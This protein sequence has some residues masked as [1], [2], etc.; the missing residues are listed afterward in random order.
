LGSRSRGYHHVAPTP[1]RYGPSVHRLWFRPSSPEALHVKRYDIP[2]LVKGGIGRDVTGQFSLRFR[3][4][5]KSQGS[6]TCRKS[7]TWDRRTDGQ[8]D[9]RLYILFEGRNAVNF[10]DRKIRRLRP[11]YYNVTV[12]NNVQLYPADGSG[13]L[14]R[15]PFILLQVC[16]RVHPNYS[17]PV[18]PFIQ[19]LW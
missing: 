2:L 18:L 7:A 15:N 19:Q 6:F 4:P 12:C 9:R 11:G 1:L 14:L 17:G 16:T 5:R 10:F 13:K 8:T 3:L